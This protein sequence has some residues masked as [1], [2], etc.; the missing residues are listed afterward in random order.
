MRA[1]NNKMATSANL[2]ESKEFQKEANWLKSILASTV[3]QKDLL[4]L[5]LNKYKLH[6]VLIASTYVKRF[7]T[8]CQKMKVSSKFINTMLREILY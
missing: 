1:E 7:L 2:N 4:N 5:L 6:K 8:N 3:K